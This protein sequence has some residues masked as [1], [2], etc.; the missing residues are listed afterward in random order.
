MQDKS[1][2][3]NRRGRIKYE[4]QAFVRGFNSR[5]RLIKTR[6]EVV[7]RES[8]AIKNDHQIMEAHVTSCCC[9]DQGTTRIE[10][11]FEKNAYTPGEEARMYCKVDNTEG[12]SEVVSVDVSLI[13]EISY[14][15]SEGYKKVFNEM[16]F[17]KSFQGL[18]VGEKGE[19]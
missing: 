16:L 11:Y 1:F 14:T 2:Q 15:S 8:G 4:L 12:K 13:N 6:Q 19:R 3:N 17:K 9:I 10:C 5:L 7:I 18:G